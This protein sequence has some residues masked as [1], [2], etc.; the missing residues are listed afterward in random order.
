MQAK[1]AVFNALVLSVLLNGSESWALTQLVWQRLR[2]L[3]AV[4][5]RRMC[6]ATLWQ[7]WQ[8]GIS[9]SELRER[10]GIASVEAYV[11]HRQLVWLGDISRMGMSRLP[12]QLLPS[13]CY[14]K[15]AVGGVC[16]TC[17]RGI[18]LALS[19]AQIDEDS[20]PKLAVDKEQWNTLVCEGLGLP[21]PR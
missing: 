12:R 4:C 9:N 1:G 8:Y 16:Y 21:E 17:G 11:F 18:K 13:W 6:R 10:L 7:Q 20:W 14:H 2:V 15:R 19:I 5:V 3:F